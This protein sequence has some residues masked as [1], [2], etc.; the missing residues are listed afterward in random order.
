MGIISY[1]SLDISYVCTMGIVPHVL[2]DPAGYAIS[3][4]GPHYMGPWGI[5]YFVTSSERKLTEI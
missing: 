5:G 4:G 3:K 2:I 1:D